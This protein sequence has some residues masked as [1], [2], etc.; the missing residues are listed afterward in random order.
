MAA[1]CC[2]SACGAVAHWYQVMLFYA[3]RRRYP[4][5]PPARAVCALPTCDA[6]R[7][8]TT[9]EQLLGDEGW[10]RIA[11]GFIAA[12]AVVPDRAETCVEFIAIDSEE[13]RSFNRARGH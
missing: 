10:Q 6:H 11:V 5:A 13:A 3:N 12:G 4:D 7:K 8:E 1:T 9:L 2:W